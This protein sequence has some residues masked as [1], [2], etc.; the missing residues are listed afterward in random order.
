MA[1]TSI[2]TILLRGLDLTVANILIGDYEMGLLSIARTMPNNV[3]SIINTMAPIFTPVFLANYSI[4]NLSGVMR[5][6]KDSIKIMALLLFVPISGFIVF[7]YDFYALWQKSLSHEELVIVTALSIITVVQAY[8]NST[9]A[10]MAQ[11]S[12]VVNKLK[13]PVIVS[14]ICGVVSVIAEIY[15]IVVLDLGLYGIVLSTTIVMILRYV[16]FNSFYAAWCL[17]EKKAVFLPETVKTWLS[18]PLLLGFMYLVRK[19]LPISSW[20]DFL[21]D[22][23]ICGF[24]GYLFMVLFYGRKYLGKFLKGLK[25]GNG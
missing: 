5:E 18:I 23:A 7:S 11:L 21:I 20:V 3:T 15:M 4:G 1:L 13:L 19:A 8:F 9:T 17:K 25:K 12:V 24:L 14:F 2:S 10:T 6:V 22:V 16:F